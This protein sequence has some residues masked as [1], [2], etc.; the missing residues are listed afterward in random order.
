MPI[1]VQLSGYLDRD[2][3]PFEL[4]N[5]TLNDESKSSGL[6]ALFAAVYGYVSVVGCTEDVV[7]RVVDILHRWGLHD[8]TLVDNENLEVEMAKSFATEVQK[9]ALN[10]VKNICFLNLMP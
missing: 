9:Y 10:K 7:D 3:R 8:N 2:G 4:G 1:V 6:V 5:F